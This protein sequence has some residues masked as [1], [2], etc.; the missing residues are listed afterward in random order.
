MKPFIALIAVLVAAAGLFFFLQKGG[1]DG[2]D[3]AGDPTAPARSETERTE[4]GGQ[5]TATLDPVVDEEERTAVERV[6][7]PT[8]VAPIA[9]ADDVVTGYG[10]LTGLV[11]GPKGDPVEGAS[12]TLTLFGSQ[13]FLTAPDGDRS[14]DVTTQTDGDGVYRFINVPVK[15]GYSLIADHEDYSKQESTGVVVVADEV[16]TV[17]PI[18]LVPGRSIRGRVTDTGGNPVEAELVLNDLMFLQG[19][20]TDTTEEEG[21]RINAAEDGTFEFKNVAPRDNYTIAVSAEGYGKIELRNISVLA[22]EDTVKDIVLEV[23]AMMGGTV[24]SSTGEPVEGAVVEA[25]S[26]DRTKRNS[27]T[28]ATTDVDGL[29]EFSDIPTGEFQ[30]VMRHPAYKQSGYLTARSGD[31]SIVVQVDPMP[32]VTGQVVDASTGQPIP[33]FTV[34]LRSVIPGSPTGQTQAVATTKTTFKDPEGRFVLTPTKVGSYVVEGIAPSYAGSYSEPF[35]VAL[36]Q[37]ATGIV[38]RLGQGG[39]IVGKVVGMNNL[40]LAGAVVQT[41]DESWSNDPFGNMLEQ[42]GVGDATSVRVR[43]ADD[44]TFTIKNLKAA[45][46][47]L[48]VEHSDYAQVIQGDVNVGEN[49][50]VRVPDIRLPK[51][52]VITGMVFGPSG[53]PISGAKVQVT[54]QSPGGS[55]RK[56]ITDDKGKFRLSKVKEGR[57][58]IFAVRPRSSAEGLFG[59]GIDQK[60]TQREIVVREGQTLTGEEFKLS[61]R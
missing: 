27:Q 41:K 34:T 55:V 24:L 25:W 4:Q 45:K 11:T 8:A 36:N 1:Q 14:S 39:T 51:G 35:E 59:E 48:V 54:P 2:P 22:T 57:Y 58:T 56:A 5:E 50:E 46:Y 18:A 28:K 43:T 40:P 7:P 29:F 23:A 47:K 61:D 15:D 42:A 20:G 52:A 49:Q 30:I 37:D 60:R 13:S 12:V 38:V 32:T 19:F 9:N 17:P 16:F 3:P 44:G 53:A 26:T 31:M 10:E 6:V 33:E 21:T